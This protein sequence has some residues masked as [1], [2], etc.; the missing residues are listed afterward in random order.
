MK[1]AEIRELTDEELNLECE[2]CKKEIFDLRL[3]IQTNQL[4]NSASI[5]LLRK[6]VARLKT[7]KSA[8]RKSAKR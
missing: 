6:D 2:R 8:R 4:E 1:P 3:K 5:G 7:E